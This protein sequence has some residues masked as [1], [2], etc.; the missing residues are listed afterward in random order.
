M[1]EKM[2]KSGQAEDELVFDADYF[3]DCYGV[4]KQ[5]PVICEWCQQKVAKISFKGYFLCEKCAKNESGE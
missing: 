4:P 1:G 3:D 2:E 5:V